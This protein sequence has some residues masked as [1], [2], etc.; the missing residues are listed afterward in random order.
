MNTSK[1]I[2]QSQ[3]YSDTKARQRHARK[4]NYRPM[5]LMNTDT[6]ILNKVSATQ[7]KQ[8][9]RTSLVAQWLRSYLPKQG[10]QVQ[11]LVREDPTFHGATKPMRH[12]Y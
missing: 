9:I 11:A 10:T 4:E 2:L 6:N 12:H 7:I 3:N 8:Y 5:S 1:L